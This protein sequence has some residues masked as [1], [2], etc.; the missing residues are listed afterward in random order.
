MPDSWLTLTNSWLG[1]T[2]YHKCSGPR[3]LASPL[4]FTGRGISST[5]WR[6]RRQGPRLGG[7][8]AASPPPRWSPRASY[9]SRGDLGAVTL[10]PHFEL[11]CHPLNDLNAT[12]RCLFVGVTS[13]W[14][15]TS[16]AHLTPQRW[17]KEVC[18]L[19]GVFFTPNALHRGG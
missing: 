13:R 12:G 17:R 3:H 1:C 2:L 9:I 15:V 8:S 14:S 19:C 6:L 4:G 18:P 7:L 5:S 11:L 10:K 16:S